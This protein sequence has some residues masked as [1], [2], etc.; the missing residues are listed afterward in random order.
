MLLAIAGEDSCQSEV[1]RLLDAGVN[2]TINA[3][4]R[5]GGTAL[6]RKIDNSENAAERGADVLYTTRTLESWHAPWRGD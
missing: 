3:T 2:I 1:E 5:N 6:L 4:D